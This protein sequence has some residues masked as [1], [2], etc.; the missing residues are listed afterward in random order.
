MTSLLIHFC[1]CTV[2][3]FLTKLYLVRCIVKNQCFNAISWLPA[4][5][6][7]LGSASAV[8]R[9]CSLLTFT[10]SYSTLYTSF[11][12][13]FLTLSTSLYFLS[14]S[15]ISITS[16]FFLHFLISQIIDYF[17]LFNFHFIIFTF[18]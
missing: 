7:D 4:A 18:S 11:H 15:H 2:F 10:F 6:S 3:V 16:D 17:S 14:L 8:C 12:F 9:L 13:H 5:L 1:I